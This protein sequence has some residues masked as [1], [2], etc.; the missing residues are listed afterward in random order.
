[1]CDEIS[2][3]QLPDQPLVRRG[4]KGEVKPLDGPDTREVGDLQPHP[5][6]FALLGVHLAPQDLIEE[7]QGGPLLLGRLGSH[8]PERVPQVGPL[9]PPERQENPLFRGI[10]RVHQGDQGRPPS[11]SSA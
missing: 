11:T 4:W 7:L 1:M 2:R 8:R 5:D 6:P 10:I 9:E 3:G